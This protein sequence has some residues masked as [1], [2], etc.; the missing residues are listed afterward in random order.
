MCVSSLRRGSSILCF[1]RPLDPANRESSDEMTEVEAK[2]DTGRSD[3]IP[4]RG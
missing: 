3:L 1:P 2:E 4:G